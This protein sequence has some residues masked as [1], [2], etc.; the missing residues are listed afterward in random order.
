MSEPETAV[1]TEFDGFLSYAN[2]P[3]KE[4]IAGVR[5]NTFGS[6]NRKARF[7]KL[8]DSLKQMRVRRH[9]H[10]HQFFDSHF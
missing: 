8:R 6:R 7:S 3:G 9:N 5:A 2:F 1:S 4:N 10:R